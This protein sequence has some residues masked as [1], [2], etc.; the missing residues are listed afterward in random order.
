VGK[1]IPRRTYVLVFEGAAGDEDMDG[2]EIRVRPPSVAEALEHHDMDWYSNPATPAAERTKRLAELYDVFAARL[3]SW[4][5]EDDGQPLPATLEGLHQLPQDIGG[6][7][8][9]SWLWETA[10]VPAP[11]PVDSNTGDASVDE[12]LIPMEASSALPS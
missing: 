11:L 6:R 2:M 1:Q 12:S 10:T 9:G 8:L 7:I 3:V 4:N 5:L